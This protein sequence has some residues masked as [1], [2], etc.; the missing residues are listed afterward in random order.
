MNKNVPGWE[1]EDFGDYECWLWEGDGNEN[2]VQVDHNHNINVSC[3]GA[4]W[5]YTTG[6]G[7]Q[8]LPDNPNIKTIEDRLAYALVLARIE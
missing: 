1:Y 3:V 8:P 7:W 2:Y 5:E 6:G 4:E